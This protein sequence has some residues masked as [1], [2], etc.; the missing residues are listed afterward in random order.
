[1]IL[2]VNGMPA[3]VTMNQATCRKGSDL[4]F[5]GITDDLY[6]SFSFANHFCK[7]N[8]LNQIKFNY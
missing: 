7:V 6:G 4:E 2:T 3:V 8:F 1:M 5:E